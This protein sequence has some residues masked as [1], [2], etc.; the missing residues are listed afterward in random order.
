V[1]QENVEIVRRLNAAFNR[2]DVAGLLELLDSTCEWWDRE[3]DP[4]ATVH[5]GHDGIRTFLAELGAHADLRVESRE[6]IDAGDDVVTPVRL[7]GRGQ[8]SGAPFEEYEVHVLRVRAGKVT[9]VR[10]YRTKAEA[11]KAVGLAE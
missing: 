3:D 6:F 11:L 9:E 4:G 8:A 1:S 7:E 5:R 2:G 10:E